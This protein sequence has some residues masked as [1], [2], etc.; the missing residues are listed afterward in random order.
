EDRSGL[1][2]GTYNVTVTDAKGCTATVSK[3]IT[4]PAV[5]AATATTTNVNCN[6]GTN[7]AIDLT[8]VGG[9]TPYTYNWGGGVT[10]EDR[11]G[12]GAGTYSVTVTDA[13]G[14]TVALS[15]TIAEPTTLTATT[16]LTNALCN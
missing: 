11:S 7:G 16:A 12:L 5:L 3:T 1:I 2:A 15:K 10:T 13:K 9:T 4:Q 14:C 8:A 6:G